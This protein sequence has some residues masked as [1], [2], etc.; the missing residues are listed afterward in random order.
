MGSDAS[1][2]ASIPADIDKEING[3]NERNSNQINVANSF[4]IFDEC[5]QKERKLDYLSRFTIIFVRWTVSY[6]L[7]GVNNLYGEVATIYADADNIDTTI[8]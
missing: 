8:P 6:A 1:Q 7:I 5:N 2:V 4:R 3:I